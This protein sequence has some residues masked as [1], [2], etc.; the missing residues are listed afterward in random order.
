MTMMDRSE[1][2]PDTP[3]AA[4]SLDSLVSVELRNWIRRETAVD[5]PLSGIMQAESLRAMATEILA[6]RAKA[7]AAAES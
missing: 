3:L 6:Q 7:D 4:F 2:S 1:V 5:L